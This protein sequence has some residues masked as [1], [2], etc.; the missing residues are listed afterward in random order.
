MGKL[1]TTIMVPKAKKSDTVEKKVD[2]K[3]LETLIPKE[4]VGIVKKPVILDIKKLNYQFYDPAGSLPAKFQ[5]D[6]P[7]SKKVFYVPYRLLFSTDQKKYE[8]LIATG[9]NYIYA[10]YETVTQVP[11]ADYKTAKDFTNF[12]M[13]HNRE[14]VIYVDD[15]LLHKIHKNLLSELIRQTLMKFRIVYSSIS[16]DALYNTPGNSSFYRDGDRSYVNFIP[17]HSGPDTVNFI[18]YSVDLEK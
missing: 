6:F 4:K 10:M 12:L 9:N 14:V 16:N 2:E 15:I 7:D 11:S 17:V 18:G 1:N 13:D 5:H 8:S 3:R